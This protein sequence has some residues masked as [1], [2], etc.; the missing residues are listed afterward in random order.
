MGVFALVNGVGEGP[1]TKPGFLSALG[2]G[3]GDLGVGFGL[4]QDTMD[5]L[6]LGYD[7]PYQQPPDHVP[8]GVRRGASRGKRQAN[9]KYTLC[10]C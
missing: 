3:V 1:E 4:L 8:V 9:L 10:Q 7:L 2:Q 5:L 6:A